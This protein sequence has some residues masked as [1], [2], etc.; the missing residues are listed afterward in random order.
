MAAA[1]APGGLGDT[2][3]ASTD[4]DNST[5]PDSRAEVDH[6]EDAENTVL[7]GNLVESVLSEDDA[8]AKSDESKK[9]ARRSSEKA[10]K[11]GRTRKPEK[12]KK[13]VVIKPKKPIKSKKSEKRKKAEKKA[14]AE[15]SP[16]DADKAERP[17]RSDKAKKVDK[18]S[19]KPAKKKREKTP[20][21]EPEPMVN[22][23]DYRYRTKPSFY[24]LQAKQ[25]A[26]NVLGALITETKKG[27][28]TSIYERAAVL[29]GVSI[30]A[31][32]KWVA[33]H[34]RNGHVL[35][36]QTKLR[37]GKGKKRKRRNAEGVLVSP[38]E[39]ERAKA[40]AIVAE[41]GDPSAP[42]K[43]KRSPKK[44]DTESA[45]GVTAPA[46][47][48]A[49]RPPGSTPR[50]NPNKEPARS[51]PAAMMRPPPPTTTTTDPVRMAANNAMGAYG[52]ATPP[53]FDAREYA[54]RIAPMIR[55][56]QLDAVRTSDSCSYVSPRPAGTEDF[57]ATR[58]SPAAIRPEGVR[59]SCGYAASPPADFARHSPVMRQQQQP[60][61]RP[62][63]NDGSNG[64]VIGRVDYAAAARN[65]PV[66]RPPDMRVVVNSAEATNSSCSFGMPPR[67][68]V[69]DYTARNALVNRV[70]Q[71]VRAADGFLRI[72]DVR[73]YDQESQDMSAAVHCAQQQQH[74][75]HHQH[76]QHQ[77]PFTHDIT[78]RPTAT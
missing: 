14:D 66:M 18:S 73:H 22:P 38:E 29:T 60:D 10:R 57:G 11:P 1:S 40:L 56:Q 63:P 61:V 25:V 19:K 30:R 17:K 21:P 58:H 71:Q 78:G 69:R 28:T 72:V 9:S 42:P 6:S 59:P 20:E 64:M 24:P 41:G 65:S 62:P 55:P 53:C 43:K 34:E 52:F 76:Q 32:F 44:K 47:K 70:Q 33:E 13:V 23:A 39:Y 37:G 31:L 54:A 8:P 67:A 50:K 46:P 2:K 48:R 45:D 77:Q 36:P 35:T 74:Q 3:K 5:E 27:S 15:K 16:T 51:V 7:P 75:Q 68:D 26:L 4:S 12:P 49:K